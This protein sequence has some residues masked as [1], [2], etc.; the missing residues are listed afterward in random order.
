MKFLFLILLRGFSINRLRLSSCSWYPRS[1]R[2]CHHVHDTPVRSVSVQSLAPEDRHAPRICHVGWHLHLPTVV[3]SP[4]VLACFVHP[5]M[6]MNFRCETPFGQWR[7]ICTGY[8]TVLGVSYLGPPDLSFSC[9][10]LNLRG[11]H[12][13]WHATL[14]SGSK[15]ADTCVKFKV[16]SVHIIFF[17]HV[18]G[19]GTNEFTCNLQSYS[20]RVHLYSTIVHQALV[21]SHWFWQWLSREHTTASVLHNTLDLTHVRNSLGRTVY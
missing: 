3:M 9:C 19:L 1:F 2:L 4:V 18:R 20:K 7:W 17:S 13:P 11:I 21:L 6:K 12:R 14:M 10:I 16:D 5:R 15:V 8:C